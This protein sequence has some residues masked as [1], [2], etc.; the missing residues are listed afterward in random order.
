MRQ[1]KLL[2]SILVLV[3]LSGALLKP[4][5][6]P[7]A[8]APACQTFEVVLPGNKIYNNLVCQAVKDFKQ[9]NYGASTSRL[10][11]AARLNLF[12][13]PNFKILPLLALSYHRAGEKKKA[14]KT[15]EHARVSLLIANGEIECVETGTGFFLD[16]H[17]QKFEHPS[18]DEIMNRMCGAIFDYLYE[19][20][21]LETALWRDELVRRYLEIRR[22]IMGE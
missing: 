8:D 22:A 15:L 16:R 4:S 12:E 9:E 21:S 19:M 5:A 10:E 17:G 1:S 6:S 3:L 7:A 2:L 11:E 14:L 20:Q 18:E 13:F